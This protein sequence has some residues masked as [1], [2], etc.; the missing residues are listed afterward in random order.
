MDRRFE[1]KIQEGWGYIKGRHDFCVCKL[2]TACMMLLNLVL[3]N[4]EFGSG[5]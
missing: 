3:L 2:V 5:L 4:S 1:G